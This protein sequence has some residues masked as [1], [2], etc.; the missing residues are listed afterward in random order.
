MTLALP[1]ETQQLTKQEWN[2]CQIV[3]VYG[4]LQSLWNKQL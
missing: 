4:Q 3:E 2:Q 1:V